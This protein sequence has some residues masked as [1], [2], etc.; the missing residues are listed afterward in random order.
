MDY[1]VLLK[2]PSK[3]TYQETIQIQNILLHHR[4][5]A[6]L[7]L[8]MNSPVV[9]SVFESAARMTKSHET[10]DDVNKIVLLLLARCLVAK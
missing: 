8:R 5:D 6:I 10:G 1:S 9:A 3:Q 2:C 4:D 7:W